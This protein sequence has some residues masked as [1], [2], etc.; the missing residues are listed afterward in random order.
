MVGNVSTV[1]ASLSYASA[2]NTTLTLSAAPGN[3]ALAGDYMLSSNL[4]LS[5]AAGSTFSTGVVTLT[6]VDNAVDAP[7]KMVMLSAT[8]SNSHGITDPAV[9]IVTI[10]DEDATPTVRL[11][12][13]PDSI[14]E[15]GAGNASTVTASLS[16]V[17]AANTRLTLAAAPGTNTLAGDYMFSSNLTLNIAAGSTVSTGTVTLTAVDNAVDAP[18]KMVMLSATASNSHGITN[19]AV[20]TV[21]IIDDEDAPTVS[22]VLTPDSISE[23]G[24]GNA[25]TVTASLSH[26]SAANTTLTLS[27]APGN[28]VLTVDYMLSSNITL[29]ITAGSTVSTGGTVTLT[30]VDNA[31]D[32]PDKMVML[33]ATA[34]NSHGITAPAVVTV[35]IRD[36]DDAPTVSL[37]PGPAA[38][39][40]NGGVST[41]TASLSH[42]SSADTTVTVAAAPGSNARSR[43]LYDQ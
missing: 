11:V 27:A 36:D 30:A 19:P 35:T 34:S 1:T 24:A 10:R 22:L 18:D 41:V 6:A 12:L 23:S 29:S 9:V 28:N 17:S 31:V 4:T 37:V 25:S 3:N 15:S 14:S 38:I 5:I 26:A 20:V 13:T 43:R 39:D 8:A 42:A 7:D 33:S 32:A 40:E 16:H 2:A 21:T